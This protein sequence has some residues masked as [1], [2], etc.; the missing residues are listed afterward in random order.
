MGFNFRSARSIFAAVLF[1]L[2][3]ALHAQIPNADYFLD[4]SGAEPVL[5]QRLYWY[6]DENVFYYEVIIQRELES[7]E[8]IN[9]KKEITEDDYIEVSLPSGKYRFRIIPYNLLGAAAES[10]EWQPFIVNKAYIPMV[11]KIFPSAFYLDRQSERI[12]DIAGNNFVPNSDIYLR[13]LNNKLFPIE[14]NI[15]NRRRAT[16][17]FDDPAL[18]P[19]IYEIVIEN[20]GGFDTAAQNFLIGYR[21]PVDVTIKS[22]WAPI[23]PVYGEIKDLLGANLYFPG[24][25]YSLGAT[26]TRRGF[27]REG[28]EF[29]AAGYAASPALVF[30]ASLKETIDVWQ[31]WI[32]TG[33]DAVWMEIGSNILIQKNFYRETM[34]LVFRAGGGFAASATTPES[35]TF[36]YWNVGLSYLIM[37]YETFFLEAGIDYSNHH[38]EKPN[39]FIKPRIGL[40]W[41]F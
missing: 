33:N 17:Y 18:I 8:F 5:L 26:S 37:L 38:S 12:L 14:L 25:I 41:Q 22:V 27:I 10:T 19:G 34:A 29:T 16:L 9:Y 28:I 1:F 11:E 21:K 7:G 30:K 6:G 23:V 40:G 35:R 20:P 31:D 36:I 4:T 13:S 39:G 15:K 24:V 32:N 3:L 2:A